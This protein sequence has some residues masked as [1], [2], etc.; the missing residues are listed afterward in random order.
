MSDAGTSDAD[1]V[2]MNQNEEPGKGK[3]QDKE[4]EETIIEKHLP[5]ASITENL[6]VKRLSWVPFWDY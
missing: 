2:Q 6:R 3:I 4:A 1:T 5:W